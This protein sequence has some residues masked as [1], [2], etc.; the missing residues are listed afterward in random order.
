M[1]IKKSNFNDWKN[2][3][4]DEKSQEKVRKN[5]IDYLKKVIGKIPFAEEVVALYLLFRDPEYP[6]I[7]KGICVFAL[8]Y[9]ITPIDLV[10]DAIPMAGFLDDAGVIAAA[11]RLYSDD[12]VTYKK[13]AKQWL[14]D[15][16]FI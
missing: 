6:L 14:K 15:N 16:G 4:P 12:I 13:K 3:E 2:R 5:F 7:K 1:D 8:L 9:F 10:P 11:I